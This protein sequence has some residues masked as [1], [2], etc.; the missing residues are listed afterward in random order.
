MSMRVIIGGVFGFV[1][2]MAN[3]T[4][5]PPGV[6]QALR[7]IAV[8]AFFGLFVEM[9]RIHDLDRSP[10]HG[11]FGRA[12]WTVVAVEIIALFVGALVVTGLFDA[13]DAVVAWVSVVVGVHFVALAAVWHQQFYDRL[14]VAIAICGSAGLG[15]AALGASAGVIGTI[16]GVVPGFLLIGAAYRPIVRNRGSSFRP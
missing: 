10:A 6:A 8:V 12:D 4:V 7:A 14:G 11:R 13:G 2:V 3:A 1:Y 16:S 5:L 15:A 9:R